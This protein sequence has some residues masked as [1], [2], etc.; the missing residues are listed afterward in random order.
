MSL[1]ALLH[2]HN[3]LHGGP[4]ALRGDAPVTVGSSDDATI[5]F[6]GSP[7]LSQVHFELRRPQEGRPA[8]VTLRSKSNHGFVNG[9]R[10][11]VGRAVELLPCADNATV[12]PENLEDP[13]WPMVF[14]VVQARPQAL[15]RPALAKTY[16]G[17]SV[18]LVPGAAPGGSACRAEARAGRKRMLD[19]PR[20]GPPTRR[21]AGPTST[22]APAAPAPE[23]ATTT[24]A[25][26]APPAKT[27]TPFAG[28]LLLMPEVGYYARPKHATTTPCALHR[29][30]VEK[31]GGTMVDELT[32]ATHIVIDQARDPFDVLEGLDRLCSS[33][34]CVAVHTEE[35]VP[36]CS[37]AARL[38]PEACLHPR[39]PEARLSKTQ[40]TP[41]QT[42]PSSQSRSR[43]P[44]LGRASSSS[45]KRG[46][47]SA[48][49][50]HAPPRRL[51]LG[52]IDEVD[53]SGM[54]GRT[55]LRAEPTP[56]P[57]DDSEG[58][59]ED[60]AAQGPRVAAELGLTTKQLIVSLLN[61]LKKVYRS[62]GGGG[63]MDGG[64]A[65][66]THYMQLSGQVETL[67]EPVTYRSILA[68]RGRHGVGKES[69]DKMLEIYRT[70]SLA[71]VDMLKSRPETAA[72]LEFRGVWGI[73]EKLGKELHSSG[74]SSVPELLAR[75][76][77]HAKLRP[78]TLRCLELHDELQRKI[79]RAECAQIEAQI[80]EVA[81]RILDPPPLRT[82]ACGSYRRGAAESRDIDVLII[83]R[84]S[85]GV[86]AAP[87][88]QLL[89]AGSRGASAGGAL[90]DTH[91]L[92][93]GGGRGEAPSE[94]SKAKV[95]LAA[96]LAL[97]D[98]LHEATLLVDDLT[99]PT[100][101]A[102]D[103]GSFAG[104]FYMGILR[105]PGGL[106][107]RIDLRCFDEEEEGAALL[108]CT[109]TDVFNRTLSRAANAQGYSLSEKVRQLAVRASSAPPPRLDPR[110]SHRRVCVPPRC[111]APANSRRREPT[112][113]C[114]PRRRSSRRCAWS[115]ASHGS[116][117]IRTRSSRSR[118]E[119]RGSKET[120]RTQ[121][122]PSACRRRG[123][124]RC[125]RRGRKGRALLGVRSRAID[126]ARRDDTCVRAPTSRPHL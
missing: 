113:R 27:K 26:T 112:C 18:E 28:V 47:P 12:A 115:T 58:E 124:I 31:K 103:G 68:L 106:H 52:S 98:A 2:P 97:I 77:L 29:G 25:A 20:E 46:G 76:D 42:S 105:L 60:A 63:Q 116:G 32:K 93:D 90:V 7:H 49:L 57:C 34:A 40:S 100:A 66:N 89:T 95:K 44:T 73:G 91:G 56:A 107:R 33:G 84:A 61:E 13:S 62:G 48:G 78:G 24:P 126:A 80:A 71:R 72:L 64:Y 69:V 118:P 117:R 50:G 120:R 45:A 5:R 67:P 10:L 51:P 22:A 81:R 65:R 19:A 102:G 17:F 23:T 108:H 123:R 79:P 109:G 9:S 88:P 125:P 99:R 14:A 35:W 111:T 37:L 104:C 75:T 101:A 121:P 43:P 119:G 86:D 6:N 70:G 92:D 96:L 74:A 21:L 3:P 87:R 41:T 122:T 83:I 55:D 94:A 11:E 1:W 38:L 85:A 110:V 15:V 30:I 36:K 4:F 8:S 82:V 114:A 54:Q 39:G 53:E 59:E 16:A